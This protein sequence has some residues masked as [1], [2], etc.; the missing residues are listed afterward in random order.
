L[1]L[2]AY[3]RFYRAQLRAISALRASRRRAAK[4]YRFAAKTDRVAAQAEHDRALMAAMA[5]YCAACAETLI[6]LVWVPEAV[7]E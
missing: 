1:P 2:L 3:K 5:D 6:K 4:Q 7:D